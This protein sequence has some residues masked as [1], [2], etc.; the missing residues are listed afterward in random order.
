M[1]DL[2][3][4]V[5]PIEEQKYAGYRCDG[6]DRPIAYPVEPSRAALLA[7][8]QDRGGVCRRG[9]SG[10]GGPVPTAQARPGRSRPDRLGSGLRFRFEQILVGRVSSSLVI[11][12]SA[13]ASSTKSNDGSCT[14]CGVAAGGSSVLVSRVLAAFWSA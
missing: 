1:E 8:A 3:V 14:G 12:S 13:G 7:R 9:A 2:E 11:S 5:A 4:H 10:E 6:V